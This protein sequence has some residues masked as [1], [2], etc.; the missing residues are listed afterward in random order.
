MHIIHKDNENTGSFIAQDGT[1]KAG[2]LTYSRIDKSA[3]SVDHIVVAETHKGKGLGR[4]L[5]NSA[6]AFARKENIKILPVCAYAKTVFERNRHIDD[7]VLRT[8][9]N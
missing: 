8:S 1:A 9:S 5:L 4:Q 2:E 3:I 7:V 6:I